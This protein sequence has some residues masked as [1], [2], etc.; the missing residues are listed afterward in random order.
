LHENWQS[1]NYR[2]NTVAHFERYEDRWIELFYELQNDPKFKGQI[3][4]PCL[5][6]RAVQAR[7]VLYVGKATAGAWDWQEDQS[8]DRPEDAFVRRHEE[9]VDS[10]VK[11]RREFTEHFLNRWA[12]GS[13]NSAFW[14]LARRLNERV[15]N[16]WNVPVTS[17]LQHIT[18]TNICKIGAQ[19]KNPG[20]SLLAR[21]RELAVAT[22]RREIDVYKPELIY[23]VTGAYAWELVKEALG[24][25]ADEV[26]EKTNEDWILRPSSTNGLPTVLRTGHPQG[27]R[28]ELV[29]RW[30]DQA[31][32][33]LPG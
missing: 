8:V 24:N 12:E 23:L 27:K 13:Y 5:S 17:N 33:L 26:W 15:A 14:H 9:P 28:R 18:W 29:E 32:E 30:L 22:L 4:A 16:K 3:S 1:W 31:V 20:S 7:S 19:K 2:G 10:L 11:D 25:P 6:V 21:Q